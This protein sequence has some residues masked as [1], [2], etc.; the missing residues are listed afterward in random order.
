[1][2]GLLELAIEVW[3][4]PFAASRVPIDEDELVVVK[5]AGADVAFEL[6][7]RTAMLGD[8]DHDNRPGRV[9]PF[10]SP[11]LPIGI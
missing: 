11:R 1:M 7:A 2:T 9:P 8:E 5:I 10:G 4:A 3:I 6:L